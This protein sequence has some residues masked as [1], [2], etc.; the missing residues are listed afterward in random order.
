LR[1]HFEATITHFSPD[2]P[3]CARPDDLVSRGALLMWA[4]ASSQ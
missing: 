2:L 3:L 1:S 4:E